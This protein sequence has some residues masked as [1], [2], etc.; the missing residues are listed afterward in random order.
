[1]IG[2]LVFAFID[3][4]S[5]AIEKEIEPRRGLFLKRKLP[6]V[7]WKKSWR[8]KGITTMYHSFSFA[9]AEWGMRAD[10]TASKVVRYIV[11]SSRKRSLIRNKIHLRYEI[12]NYTGVEEIIALIREKY[13]DLLWCQLQ[14]PRCGLKD[15]KV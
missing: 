15:F 10:G 9:G 4:H 8:A 5:Y 7:S 1:M 6:S 13:V 2:V 14:D 11:E 3:L 12:T